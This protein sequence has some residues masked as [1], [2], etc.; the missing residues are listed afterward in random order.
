MDN[1]K[2][3]RIIAVANQKGGVGKT[4]TAINLSIGLTQKGYK[5]LAIDL[6]SQAHLAIGLGIEIT[7]NQHTLYNLINDIMNEKLENIHDFILETKVKNL[8]LLPS[9]INL[10]ATELYLQNLT[11]GKEYILKKAIELLNDEF[12][13]IIL[14]CPPALGNF[15]VN[16]LTAANEVI[17]PMNAAIFDVDGSKKLVKT[18]FQ[19][20]EICNDNLSILGILLTKFD[21]RTVHAK[22][23]LDGLKELYGDNIK[24][25][26]SKIPQSI[27]VAESNFKGISIFEHD[28]KGKVAI[29]YKGLVDEVLSI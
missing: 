13:F 1:N 5:V 29:A 8:Y 17:I 28:P 23:V 11:I 6:D 26:D 15:T 9:D 24:I 20:K 7:D 2:K 4:T 22:E 25:F 27:K 16:A 14:D 3:T 18:I 21:N 19:V 12:D 10:A